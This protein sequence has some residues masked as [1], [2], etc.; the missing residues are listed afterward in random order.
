MRKRGIGYR[1]T[2]GLIVTALL[3]AG[4]SILL[5]Y[6]LT[7]RAFNEYTKENRIQIG[8]EV[9]SLLG[10]TYSQ[11]GWD[12][13]EALVKETFLL[14][15]SRGRRMGMMGHQMGIRMSLSQNDI[16][17]TDLY[18]TIMVSSTTLEPGS[19]LPKSLLDLKVPIFANKEHVGYVVVSKPISPNEK[20]LES[21]FSS[22]LSRYSLWVTLFGIAAAVLAGFFTSGQL[23]KPIKDLSRAVQLFTKGNRD[24]RI[25][26][27]SD[28]EL[29]SL[30][31]DFNQ[32]AEAIKT[33]EELRK[34][35]T[36]DVAH[37]LRTPLSILRGTLDSI[38]AGVLEAT[39][40]V[41]LSLQDETIRMSRLIKDLSDLSRAE[42]GNLDLHREIIRPS[43]LKDK[44]SYLQTET[45]LKGIDFEIDIP[46]NLPEISVDVVRII[47]VISNLLN[48]ALRH[49]TTGKIQLTAEKADNGVMFSVTDTGTGIKKED[50]PLVFER[51]YREDKSRSRKTGGMGLGLSIAKGIVEA[52]G[53]RIW[54]ESK[55]GQGSI[56]SFLLPYDCP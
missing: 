24:V 41:I 36:A 21:V 42:A 29:G 56:F 51:F 7:D 13:I 4:L 44:F 34:S 11:D 38:Q 20:S 49:T 47:Q 32:M 15:K 9:S 40:D 17:V 1:I 8:W 48:N 16:V 46:D 3:T 52:H 5:F 33:S 54:V 14:R 37:E 43:E 35:L 28:D 27:K 10:E 22:T 26:V 55:E 6:N 50:L 53:G 12:G 23:I 39:P 19:L 30:A 18:D 45:E 2:A 25:P 31:A